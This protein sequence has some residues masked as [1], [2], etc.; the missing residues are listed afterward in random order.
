MSFPLDTYSESY[1]DGMVAVYNRETATEPHIAPLTPERFLE[2]VAPKSYFDPGGLLVAVDG[3]EVVGWVHACHAPGSQR[4]HDSEKRVARIRMLLFPPDRMDVG[5]RLVAAATEWCL[6]AGDGEVLGMHSRE[7]YPFYRCLWMGGEPKIPVT[8]PH[9]HAALARAGFVATAES[10]FMAGEVGEMPVEF[11]AKLPLQFIE[12]ET[13]MAHEPM[14][15]SWVGFTPMEIRALVAGERVGHI[16]WALEPYHA[17][18]LGAPCVNIWGMSVAEAH[19]RRGIASALVSR[20]LRRGYELG[21]RHAS[22]STQLWNAPAQRTYARLGFRPYC[23]TIGRELRS[24][25]V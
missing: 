19:R 1:L 18:T 24:E 23:M 20:V 11:S 6:Q 15:E 5:E 7:G 21:A 22:V 8:F 14:R 9:L 2:L 25:S 4:R 13:E 10:V 12:S 17:E 16:A 3:G